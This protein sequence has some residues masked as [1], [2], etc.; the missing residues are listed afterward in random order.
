MWVA[1]FQG[2]SEEIKPSM[3]ACVS[4]SLCPWLC[5]C[6][7]KFW[8]WNPEVMMNH[9]LELGVKINLLSLR[10]LLSGLVFIRASEMKSGC[11]PS[12]FSSHLFPSHPVSK[13]NDSISLVEPCFLP[14]SGALYAPMLLAVLKTELPVLPENPHQPWGPPLAFSWSI[15]LSCKPPTLPLDPGSAPAIQLAPSSLE[16]CGC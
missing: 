8:P 15:F 9:S 1:S 10:L 14:Q 11:S 4:F 5:I 16:V 7:S 2:L 13:K 12:S 6:W 3:Q